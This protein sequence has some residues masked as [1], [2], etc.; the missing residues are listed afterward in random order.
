M[1]KL[2]VLN[3]TTGM[4]LENIT[5]P[6]VKKPLFMHSLESTQTISLV[7]IMTLDI[8]QGVYILV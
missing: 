8:Y 3:I 7:S 6:E 5:R 1:R 4:S 2:Y